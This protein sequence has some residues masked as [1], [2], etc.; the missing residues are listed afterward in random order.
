M[1][2]SGMESAEECH[3]PK[4][5]RERFL[6]LK[7]PGAKALVDRGVTFSGVSELTEPY[8]VC[9]T[10]P[11]FHLV[12]FTVR[13]SG[14]F[15]TPT[16]SGLLDPGDL[17][18]VPAQTRQRYWAVGDWKILFF[19]I[20]ARH[21]RGVIPYREPLVTP[22]TSMTQL[23]S[24][25]TW[26]CNEAMLDYD[27]SREVAKAYAEI[28]C[29]CLDRELDL[30]ASP[31]KTHARMRLD[32]LWETVNGSL[33]HPWP[34]E[35]MAKRMH[36]SPAQF[37]RVVGQVYRASPSEILQSMRIERAKQLLR[38]TDDSLE[39]I[40]ERVGYESP[41]SL[42]RAFKR[43]VGRSPREFKNDRSGA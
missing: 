19:H 3:I 5:C 25:M 40:A 8:R 22:A 14:R 38:R 34:V 35:A 10:K 31:G 41:F 18:I 12:I 16:L 9:R 30:A 11:P 20:D 29:I 2:E 13:G 43:A 23:E 4:T 15:E 1:I 33:S 6:P 24:A 7:E 39:Q 17:W 26:L 37:R 32:A 42:S 27:R 36:L 21:P 28:T